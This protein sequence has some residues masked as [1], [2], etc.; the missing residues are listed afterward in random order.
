MFKSKTEIFSLICDIF[1][2]SIFYKQTYA[3]SSGMVK[4]NE[5]LS[6]LSSHVFKIF[7]LKVFPTIIITLDYT[8]LIDYLN[9]S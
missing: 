7:M 5:I 3:N 1:R 2:I 9:Y 8:R 4:I 6:S